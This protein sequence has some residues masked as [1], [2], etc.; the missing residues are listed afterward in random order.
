MTDFMVNLSYFGMSFLDPYLMFLTAAGVFFG[1]YI[2][3][4]PGL[5]VTMAVSIL[6]SFTFKWQVNEALA[7][8]AGIYYG[9]VYGGSRSAILINVPGAPAA[10][11]SALDG[12]PLAKRGE[13]GQAIGLT[14][15]MGVFGGLLGV[16]VLAIGA[17]MLSKLALLFAP[18]DY[19]MLAIWGLLLVG[20]LSG[21][22]MAKGIFAGALGILFGTVGLDP[23]TAEPRFTFGS[24]QLTAG[25]PYVAAMIGLFG[26]SEVLVQLHE[27]H[28][29]TVKQNVSKLLPPWRLIRKHLPLASRC[30]LLGVVVGALPGA[31]GDI[32]ALMAYDHAKRTVKNPERPFGEGAWEGVVAPESAAVG[33]IGGAYIP[34]LT[35]GIPGDA[36]TAVII[37][38]LYIH[39]M[40][41]GPM[42][43]IETPHL[44]WFTV[45]NLALSCIFLGIFGFMGIK[46]FAKIVEIPKAALLPMIVVL[47]AVGSYAIENNPVHIYWMLGFGVAGYFLKMYGFQVGPIILG[48]IL[49]PLLDTNYRRAM[50]SAGESPTQFLSEFFTSPLSF[51]LVVMLALTVLSQTRYWGRIAGLFRR[52]A[53]G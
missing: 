17:P 15:V 31:G 18:R 8:I 6:I 34:M 39:G 40:K 38:A 9:G 52:R 16:A 25:A 43:L 7:L 49:G 19:M 5:S 30:S 23:L 41:P 27:L 50:I 37:G 46:L 45:G 24:V 53:A 12:Y 48:I 42:M 35:L 36:V 1:I 32:A 44:F 26:V 3:A 4:I 20:S 33:A 2:G 10:I 13:A 11:A 21:G 51:V 14:T 22:M 29:P 47:S 28:F